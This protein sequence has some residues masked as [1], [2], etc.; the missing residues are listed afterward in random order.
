MYSVLTW[1][2]CAQFWQVELYEDPVNGEPLEWG[3]R[4][5]LRH[6]TTQRYLTL[7]K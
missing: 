4:V 3:E 2:V 1:D 5:R 6:C 7:S